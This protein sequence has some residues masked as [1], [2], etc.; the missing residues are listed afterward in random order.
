MLFFSFF[1]SLVEKGATV[2]V[3]LKNDTC[4]TGTLTSVDQYLNVKLAN[5]S[6]DDSEKHPYLLGLRTCFIRGSTVRF[7]HLPKKDV[8]LDLLQD[9]CRREHHKD[10]GIT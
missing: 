8:E 6:V 9:A 10:R 5:V 4:V 7:V 2:T 3:E 1:Q